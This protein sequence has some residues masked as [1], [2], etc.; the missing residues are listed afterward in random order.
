MVQLQDGRNHHEPYQHWSHYGKCRSGADVPA[1][2]EP[3][4]TRPGDHPK[5]PAFCDAVRSEPGVR[6]D[7][8]S[9][10]GYA[11]AGYILWQMFLA[12]SQRS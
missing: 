12:G 10:D 5:W 4:D 8:I 7:V 6:D 9:R 2:I 11:A 3:P 1:K